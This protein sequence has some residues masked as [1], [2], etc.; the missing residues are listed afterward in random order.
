MSDFAFLEHL[1]GL[2]SDTEHFAS[3]IPHRELHYVVEEFQRF[4][5]KYPSRFTDYPDVVELMADV[6]EFLRVGGRIEMGSKRTIESLRNFSKMVETEIGIPDW[7]NSILYKEGSRVRYDKKTW[8]ARKEH[9]SFQSHPPNKYPYQW[10]MV[11][12]QQK[13]IQDQ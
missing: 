6:R 11:T 12:E 7:T 4:Y 8:I 9:V 3:K 13:S 2:V 1:K 10:D 5:E